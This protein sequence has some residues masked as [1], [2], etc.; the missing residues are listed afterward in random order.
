MSATSENPATG[1]DPSFVEP[2]NRGTILRTYVQPGAKKT[3]WQGCYGDRLKLRIQAPPA[4]GKANKEL[5]RF[6][7]KSL[8]LPKSRVTIIRGNKNRRKD[9]LLEGVEPQVIRRIFK[10]H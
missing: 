5:R 1:P 7:G 8:S 2:H 6:L 3:E 10:A 9:I 4:N